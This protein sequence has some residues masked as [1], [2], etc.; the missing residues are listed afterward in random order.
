M[1]EP[2]TIGLAISAAS[3]VMGY[4]N[5]QKQA[6]EQSKAI[7]ADYNNKQ[8]T[9]N[10]NAKQTNQRATDDMS[11]RAREAMIERGRLQVIG[12]ESGLGTGNL[13]RTTQQSQFNQG[14]DIA[15]IEGN[16]KNAIAQNTLDSRSVYSEA[17]SRT[18]QIKQPSLIGAGLQIGGAGMD[19]YTKTSKTTSHNNAFNT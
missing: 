7:Q 19:Y 18:N 14:Y 6:D 10:E 8:A 3:A 5:Q 4:M 1:C 2:V 9:L 11:A 16:R 12:G 17:Q 13:D 15:A